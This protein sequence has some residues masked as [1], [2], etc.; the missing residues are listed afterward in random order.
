MKK[1]VILAI[2]TVTGTLLILNLTRHHQTPV[3]IEFKGYKPG[4]TPNLY[5]TGGDLN[6]AAQH[7]DDQGKTTLMVDHSDTFICNVE[8][9][10]GSWAVGSK[11]INIRYTFKV[12]GVV[13]DSGLPNG[14][15]G[16]N[17]SFRLNHGVVT[18]NGSKLP[19]CI[20]P[21]CNQ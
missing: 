20:N 7:L 8:I 6:W 9:T 4:Q 14:Q 21:A 15:G 12:K 18:P 13:I 11:G 16:Y 19:T 1:F 2:V 3:D 17:Y 10:N 5:C